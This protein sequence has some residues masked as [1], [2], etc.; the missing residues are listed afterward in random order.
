MFAWFAETTIMAALLAAVAGLASHTNKFGPAGR[1]ALWLVVLLKMITP[2]IIH[3]PETVVKR[4]GE[5]DGS[6]AFWSA[7]TRPGDWP[8]TIQAEVPPA[9]LTDAVPPIIPAEIAGIPLSDSLPLLPPVEPPAPPATSEEM[10]TIETAVDLATDEERSASVRALV[11]YPTETVASSKVIATGPSW[12]IT[13]D[14]LCHWGFIAWLVGASLFTTRQLWRIARFSDV[15][16]NAKPAPEWMLDA[17]EDTAARVGVRP[18][19]ARVVAMTGSPFLWCAGRATLVIPSRLLNQLEPDCWQGILAHELAHLKRYDPWVCRL[20]LVAGAAWWWNPLYW[21]V[22]G[23]LETEAE[24]SCDAM[25]VSSQPEARRRFAESLV[26]VCETLSAKPVPPAL[27][28]GSE[29]RFLERRL[30]M[31]LNGRDSGRLPLRGVLATAFLTALSLPSWTL[32]QQPSP[33]APP[34]SPAAPA[35]PAPPL[36]PTGPITPAV[37]ESPVV[38]ALPAVPSPDAAPARSE[39][40][41]PPPS[42]RVREG[43]PGDLRPP[44]TGQRESVERRPTPR[45]ADV[46]ESPRMNRPGGRTPERASDAQVPDLQNR[47]RAIQDLH[48]QRHRLAEETQAQI[49]RLMAQMKG[50]EARLLQAESE[51]QREIDALKRNPEGVSNRSNDARPIMTSPRERSNRPDVPETSG[52]IGVDST[53]SDAPRA[54]MTSPRVRSRSPESNEIEQLNRRMDAME[55]KLDLLLK[56][57]DV[58]PTSGPTPVG[59]LLPPPAVEDVLPSIPASPTNPPIGSTPF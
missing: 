42:D 8:E 56:K 6:P 43:D 7:R 19:P 59:S 1:H 48:T 39:D 23:R 29:G 33:D 12:R 38:P 18:P 27:G 35:T 30:L 41:P 49:N 58:K 14:K 28:V 52:R 36:P 16:R 21:L 55:K 2:P 53:R 11:L 37:P 46:K 3:W 44:S 51:M 5:S 31:I 25:A 40:P 54:A 24:L 26:A 45:S 10:A 57:L 4:L 50:N 15:L 34:I 20:S 17:I 32:A 9:D 22:R 13:E 47:I